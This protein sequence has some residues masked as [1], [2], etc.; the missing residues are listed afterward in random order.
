MEYIIVVKDIVKS[1]NGIKALYGVST[2]IPD[3]C[4][5]CIIGPNGAGK[6]TFL[7]IITGF[8]FPDSGVVFVKG[9]RIESFRDAKEFVSFM[10]E[11]MTLYPDYYVFEFLSFF[12]D[13]TGY[14]DKNILEFL[15]LNKI[16]SKRIK[17][18]SKGWH[19]RLKLYIAL[20]PR[21]AISV[22]D[23]PFEGFDPLKM[24]E[25]ESLLKDEA[26]NRAFVLSIHQL[27]YAEKICDRYI[28]LSSGRIVAEGTLRELKEKYS[29]NKGGIEDIFVNA[30]KNEA[31]QIDY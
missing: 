10:P 16:Y 9:R 24:M 26:K 31:G 15:K 21:R 4:I 5:T 3:N 20:A 22:L 27:N 28:L 30:I 14:R 23:E 11:K 2:Q 18:L 29:P 7:K 25:I 6:S 8:D 13:I 12:H 17:E 19:Q 1:Y